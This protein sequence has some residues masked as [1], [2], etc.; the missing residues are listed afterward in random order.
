MATITF[1]LIN[2]AIVKKC[3]TDF[4]LL[5]YQNVCH[6]YLNPSS[7]ANPL[8]SARVCVCVCACVCYVFVCVFISLDLSGVGRILFFGRA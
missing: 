2:I 8:C 7:N 4:Q 6:I 3:F 5:C 1:Q